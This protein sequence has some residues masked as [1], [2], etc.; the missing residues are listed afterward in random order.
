MRDWID[1]NIL[2]PQN[3]QEV[4]VKIYDKKIKKNIIVKAKFVD[5]DLYRSWEFKMPKNSDIT[6]LP[7]H[8]RISDA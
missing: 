7:T 8:W 4:E 6:H 2:T 5:T 3:N 1:V